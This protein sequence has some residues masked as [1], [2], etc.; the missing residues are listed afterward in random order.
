MFV[1][2]CQKVLVICN[3]AGNFPSFAGYHSPVKIENVGEK[4]VVT[5]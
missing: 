5:P 3:I 4:G 2:G 1:Q